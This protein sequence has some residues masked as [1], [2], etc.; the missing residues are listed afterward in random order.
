MLYSP[1]SIANYFLDLAKARGEAISP[2]KLQKL[3]YYA[4]GWYAGHTGKPLIDEAVEAWQYG[5]VIPSLYH[6]FKEFGAGQISGKATHFDGMALC[7]VPAPADSELRQF[8]DNI[9]SSYGQF[10]GVRLSEMTHATNS[11]WDQT[12]KV[13]GGMRGVDIPFDKIMDY[14]R[15]AI[16]NA[17]SGKA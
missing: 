15:T 17:N 6:E 10:T 7:E 4:H 8:L 1:K 9:W 14:F 5:P 12:W 16:G 13:S 11:P 2:M 3:V